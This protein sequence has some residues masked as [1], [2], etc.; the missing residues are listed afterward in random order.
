MPARLLNGVFHSGLTMPN[1]FNHCVSVELSPPYHPCFQETRSGYWKIPI[2]PSE[3]AIRTKL[4]TRTQVL[5]NHLHTV[6][7]V[8]AQVP[9]LVMA[10]HTVRNRAMTGHTLT[11]TCTARPCLYPITRLRS[12]HLKSLRSRSYHP[13][14]RAGSPLHASSL[15]VVSPSRSL[16]AVSSLSCRGPSSLY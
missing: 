13:T 6:G 7:T 5:A 9:H 2:L 12:L 8:R 1:K 11:S 3:A 10:I 16:P 4:A 15:S 14:N